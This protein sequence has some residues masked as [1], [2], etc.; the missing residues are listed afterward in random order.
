MTQNM[1]NLIEQESGQVLTTTD[2]R[3]VLAGGS[4]LS[5]TSTTSTS[6]IS[7]NSMRPT[8]LVTGLAVSIILQVQEGEQKCFQGFQKASQCRNVV[9][10]EMD[11][12]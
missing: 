6:C 10:W 3:G 11:Q 2:S 9:I 12:I 7:G 5:W 1:G 4:S 8:V